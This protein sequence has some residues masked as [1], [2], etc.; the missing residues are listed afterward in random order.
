MK[1]DVKATPFTAQSDLA[2]E[3]IS[4]REKIQ[5]VMVHIGVSPILLVVSTFLMIFYTDVVGLNPAAVGTLFLIA[6]IMDGVSDPLMGYV[7]DHMPRLRMGKF[8]YL[9][10]IGVL[11]CCLNFLVLWFGPVWATTGKLAIAYVSYLLLGFTYDI[12]DISKN[13]LLPTMTSNLKE[14]NKLGALMAFGGLFG[15]MGVSIAVPLILAA[16]NSSLQSYFTVILLS[17]GF[18]MVLSITGV[19]GVK[20]RVRPI[21]ENVKY[22]FKGYLKILTQRPVY[23]LLI[24]NILFATGQYLVGAIGAYYF[25]Y[26]INDLKILGTVSLVQLVGILPGIF[27]ASTIFKWLGKKRAV[28]ICIL[29]LIVFTLIRL[30]D[31]TSIPLIFLSTFVLGFVLGLYMTGVNIMQAD[32]IDY[33]EYRM[34]IRSEAAQSSATSFVS[35]VGSGLAGALPGFALAIAGYIPGGHQQPAS[36]TTAIIIMAIVV[37]VVFYAAS[38]MVI[39]F[40]YKLDKKTLE[41]VEASLSGQRTA[42]QV[43]KD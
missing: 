43:A 30:L 17:V 36:V 33:T 13:S 20:E 29:I 4:L 9:L 3:K 28:V 42:K 38:T 10:I 2:L 14:R 35:K 25:T 7:L 24:F 23:I 37:P 11:V 39:G 19:M 16:G 41:E 27:L 22:S 12:M 26:V 32:N 21:Q 1:N 8:R 5:F 31:P 18:V 15:A 40:G 6:R 34:H